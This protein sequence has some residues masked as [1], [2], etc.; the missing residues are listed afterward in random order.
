LEVFQH[1]RG[2][3]PTIHALLRNTGL[4]HD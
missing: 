3:A 1:F 2:R 4:A